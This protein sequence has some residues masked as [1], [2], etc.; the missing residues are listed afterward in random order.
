MEKK[1][2]TKKKSAKQVT[3][4][5]KSTL[6]F[7]DSFF[8]TL[9]KDERRAK[10]L[11]EATSGIIFPEDAPVQLCTLDDSVL[12]RYN[13][14]GVAIANQLIVLHEQQSTI[15]PNMPYRL[16]EYLLYTY[17]KWFMD[18]KMLYGEELVKIPMPKF[19]VLYNGEKELTETTLKLSSAFLMEDGGGVDLELVVHV[20]DINYERNHEVLDKSPSLKGYSYL[21]AKIRE[22][23]KEGLSRDVAIAKAV[24]TCI[25]EDILADF[26][27]EHN[28]EEV[29]DMLDF[30]YKLED[31]LEVR[32]A[33]REQKGRLEA[34][35]EVYFTEMNLTI[36]QIAEK[37]GIGEKDVK[38]TLNELQLV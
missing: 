19:Y 36:Q 11:G 24:R 30:E 21:I 35:V 28:Y 3:S 27:N 13:D 1:T 16:L 25:N 2:E 9:Y 5:P 31:E 33:Q 7:K 14:M 22:F 38:A 8:R 34:L 15:N 20:I 6:K 23:R 12:N 32:G 26:L 4:P 29:C 17:G 18:K 37:L 10:E